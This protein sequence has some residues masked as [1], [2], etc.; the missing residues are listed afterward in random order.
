MKQNLRALL[1]AISLALIVS[2][3]YQ[4]QD[5][6]EIQRYPEISVFIIDS[7]NFNGRHYYDT[8]S[9]AFSYEV[10]NIDCDESLRIIDSIATRDSWGVIQLSQQSRKYVKD[11]RWYDADKSLDTIICV[12][13][14]RDVSLVFELNK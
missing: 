12:C 7:I 5:L 9:L 13:N 2:C 10:R 1:Y 11:V 8:G 4:S 3:G 14:E 6:K